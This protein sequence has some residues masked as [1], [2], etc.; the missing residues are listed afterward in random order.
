MTTL[1]RK[2][3][4]ALPP[5]PHSRDGRTCLQLLD[6]EEVLSK[7][8]VT[9][10]ALLLCFTLAGQQ[11]AFASADAAATPLLVQ[12]Q[13]AKRG[14][15]HGVKLIRADGSEIKGRIVSLGKSSV[16]LQ[17]K[18]ATTISTVPYAEIAR[19]KGPG[20]ST[21]AKVGIGVGIGVVVTVGIL[22][23]AINHELNKP[24]GF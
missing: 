13:L 5:G 4:A 1:P 11:A 24:W 19:V 8:L 14:V 15:G 2:S 7:H 9:F 16:D 10:F 12:S 3:L 18:G 21:G 22:A 20:L 23:I 17:P 6:P